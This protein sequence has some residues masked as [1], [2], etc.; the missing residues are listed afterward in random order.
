MAANNVCFHSLLIPVVFQLLRHK[1]HVMC[2]VPRCLMVNLCHNH[3]LV[4]AKLSNLDRARALGHLNAGMPQNRVAQLFGVSLSTI[5]RLRRRF[6]ETGDVK[7]R[8]RSGRPRVT[9]GQDDLYIRMAALRNRR[10]NASQLQMRMRARHV[11]IS[12]QTVRN[13]LHAAGLRA[14]KPARKPLLTANHRAHRL[15]WCRAHRGWNFQNW[16]QVMF[17]DESRFCLRNV[18]G[19][20]KVWRRQ[21]ERFA[22]CCIERTTA[23]HGGSVMVW[24]GISSGG[25]TELIILQGNLNAA[26][27]QQEILD[28]VAIPYVRALGPNAMLQDDNARPHR[29]RIITD[30]LIQQGIQRMEWPACSPDLNPIEHLWD[31]LGR[32]VRERTDDVTTLQDLARILVEEWDAIPQNRIRRLVQSMRRRCQAVIAA[33]GGSTRY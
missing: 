21:G 31:Q 1:L 4:M 28:P 11:N 30:H 5:K 23:F 18:D 2:Q 24:G 32:A 3:H 20:V 14:R 17:S 15:Q 6:Q 8:P 12:D 26:R 29:A 22:D 9:T 16:N 13:R 19:R 7:D 27:Y 25:R 33:F 10:L